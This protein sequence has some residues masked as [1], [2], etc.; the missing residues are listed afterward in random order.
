MTMA[1]KKGRAIHMRFRK[2]DPAHNLLAATQHWIKANGG[3]VV[4]IGGIGLMRKPF[5]ELRYQ[6][7]VSCMGKPPIKPTT[8][9]SRN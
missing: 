8:V 9:I 2:N 5:D 3:S 6:I 4:V 1:K 7:V